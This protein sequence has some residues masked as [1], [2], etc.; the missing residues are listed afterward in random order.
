MITF[1]C[2]LSSRFCASKIITLG[3][4]FAE[5]FKIL[6]R[7]LFLRRSIVYFWR[8]YFLEDTSSRIYF[9]QQFFWPTTY[10]SAVAIVRGLAGSISRSTYSVCCKVPLV[11]ERVERWRVVSLSKSIWLTGGGAMFRFV[12]CRL[13]RHRGI[14]IVMPTAW[15]S[16]A[17]RGGRAGSGPLWVTDSIH[18]HSRSC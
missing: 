5:L 17:F 7:G 1:L 2:K 16:G 18:R 13:V 8:S 6:K 12:C 3:S 4:F 14:C 10:T 11:Q 15:Y 9:W